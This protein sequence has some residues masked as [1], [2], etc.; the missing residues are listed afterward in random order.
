MSTDVTGNLACHIRSEVE[1]YPTLSTDTTIKTNILYPWWKH[2]VFKHLFQLWATTAQVTLTSLAIVLMV[3]RDNN[4]VITLLPTPYPL[5]NCSCLYWLIIGNVFKGCLEIDE[6]AVVC[7]LLY[8]S[9]GRVNWGGK[10]RGAVGVIACVLFS[11][12]L[13]MRNRRLF[14]WLI[15]YPVI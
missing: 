6:F 15:Y 8:L 7:R 13:S 3:S 5:F 11:F 9:L 1:N 4:Y 2:T 12:M 14:L 10:V